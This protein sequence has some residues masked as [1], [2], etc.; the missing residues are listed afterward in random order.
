MSGRK[1]L[2]AALVLVRAVDS[3]ARLAVA[4]LPHVRLEVADKPAAQAILDVAR[5]LDCHFVVMA[6]H[7]RGGLGRALLGS[8]ADEV[9][10]QLESGAVLLARPNAVPEPPPRG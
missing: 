6:T 10:R 1:A 2:F 8:V 5:R 4:G 7:G 9:V 3:S